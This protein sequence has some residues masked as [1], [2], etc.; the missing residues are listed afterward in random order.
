MGKIGLV[1]CAML[2][3]IF[4]YANAQMFRKSDGM[5]RGRSNLCLINPIVTNLNLT[6]EQKEKIKNIH[7]TQMDELHLLQNRLYDKNNELRRFWLEQYP[8]Q[9]KINIVTQ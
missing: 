7:G 4:S 2:I 1:I 5:C 8:N 9:S 3:L 6:V